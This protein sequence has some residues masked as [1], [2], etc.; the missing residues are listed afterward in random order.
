M[1][2][3]VYP[4]LLLLSLLTI[5]PG[6]DP[7]RDT[8][9]CPAFSSATPF[10]VRVGETWCREPDGLELTFGPILEDSRCNVPGVECVWAGR[11][12]LALTLDD[13]EIT[14]DTFR[15]EENWQDTLHYPAFD[16]YLDRVLPETRP[17]VE[18]ADTSAYRLELRY[19]AR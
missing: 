7:S 14:R 17:T 9:Q 15:A 16:L 5:L 3:R 18:W 2:H 13:G 12:V 4:S 10:T 6:C 1:I 11:F 19:I 8:L